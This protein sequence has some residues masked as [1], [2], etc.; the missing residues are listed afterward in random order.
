MWVVCT[1]EQNRTEQIFLFRG[2]LA[3][4]PAFRLISQHITN[5]HGDVWKFQYSIEQIH[6]YSIEVLFFH[7]VS[8]KELRRTEYLR[9]RVSYSA[10]L[11]CCLSSRSIFCNNSVRSLSYSV[12]S[13]TKCNSSSTTCSLHTWHNLFSSV[14]PIKRPDYSLNR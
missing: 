13:R 11:S 2:W 1:V 8:T 7:I 3:W 5:N 6:L 14:S 9:T 10:N 4:S 12:H